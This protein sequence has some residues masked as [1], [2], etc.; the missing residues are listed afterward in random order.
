M[1]DDVKKTEWKTQTTPVSTLSF[2]EFKCQLFSVQE[3]VRKN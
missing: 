3:G 2:D 1:H